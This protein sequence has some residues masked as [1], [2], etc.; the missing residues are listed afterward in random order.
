MVVGERK[1]P[2]SGGGRY[3][4]VGRI[5]ERGQNG[6][7]GMGKTWGTM[8]GELVRM[9]VGMSRP[10]GN[11]GNRTNSPANVSGSVVVCPNVVARHTGRNGL[12]HEISIQNARGVVVVVGT[13]LRNGLQ[14]EQVT[15]RMR[16]WNGT[17]KINQ[18]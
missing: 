1:K 2:T 12:W 3:Q 7:K 6:E 16:W 18:Q 13:K 17:N 15:F 4:L 5:N 10:V 14:R 9:N 8:N 11:K